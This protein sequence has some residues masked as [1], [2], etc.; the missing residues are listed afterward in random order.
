M[1]QQKNWGLRNAKKNREKSSVTLLAVYVVHV[2]L[3]TYIVCSMLFNNMDLKGQST[4]L[5]QS[6]GKQQYTKYL[7]SERMRSIDSP[8][9]MRW[10]TI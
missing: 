9:R 8:P 1:L 5:T 7:P 3:F 10:P 4:K 6:V 2:A